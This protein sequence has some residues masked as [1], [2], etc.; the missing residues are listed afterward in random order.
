M[1]E[2]SSLMHTLPP[3]RHFFSEM[4]E[5]ILYLNKVLEADCFS[6][7]EKKNELV[8]NY[9]IR[10]STHRYIQDK[11]LILASRHAEINA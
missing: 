10:T 4:R 11:L 1:L 7:M 5:G 9:F 2:F 3:S 6:K 8:C